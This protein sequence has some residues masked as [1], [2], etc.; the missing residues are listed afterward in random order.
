[1]SLKEKIAN[2][3]PSDW[4]KNG[5]TDEE[6]SQVVTEAKEDARERLALEEEIKHLEKDAEEHQKMGERNYDDYLLECASEYRQL[7]EWLRELKIYKENTKNTP[8]WMR[9]LRAYREAHEEI[10]ALPQIW[11]EGNGI[12]KCLRCI[13][14]WLEKMRGDTE[15]KSIK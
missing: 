9:E 15:W 1:M 13:E 12:Q 3:E 4:L 11:E 7:A 10:K 14:R 2:A 5:M 8:K 6:V